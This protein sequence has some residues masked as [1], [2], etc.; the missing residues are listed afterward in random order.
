MG[1][2]GMSRL[3]RYIA[4]GERIAKR[5]AAKNQFAAFQNQ[6]NKDLKKIKDKLGKL[7]AEA[8]PIEKQEEVLRYA[9]EP[10]VVA[11]REK[12]PIMRDRTKV[13]VTI[14]GR[15]YEYYP[16]NLKA[17]IQEIVFKRRNRRAL[18]AALFFGPR[19]TK[20]RGKGAKVRAFG[21]TN[22]S[23]DAFYAA[24]V[25]FGTSKQSPQPFMRPA[26]DQTKGMILQRAAMGMR[27]L[28]NE[29]KAKNTEK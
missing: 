24:M 29:W 26:F 20:K 12:A 3:D 8:F 6:L 13:T 9:S 15:R 22:K 27:R 16:G 17:S 25:E 23:V 5:G 11:A 2:G 10:L 18:K 4:E 21:K 1:V 14:S 28:M 7:P 19:V